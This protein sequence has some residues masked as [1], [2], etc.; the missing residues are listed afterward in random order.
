MN[1]RGL[2][3][4]AIVIIVIAVGVVG[5]VAINSVSDSPL[6]SPKSPSAQKAAGLFKET[7]SCEDVLDEIISGKSPTSRDI[8]TLGECSDSDL[9]GYAQAQ[10]TRPQAQARRLQDA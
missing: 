5:G 2:G 4:I 1:K 9:I 3:I 8:S 6:F 7:T 10:G